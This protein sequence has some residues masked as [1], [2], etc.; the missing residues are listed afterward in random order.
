MFDLDSTGVVYLIGVGFALLIFAGALYYKYDQSTKLANH[1]ILANIKLQKL[2]Q[3]SA[4]RKRLAKAKELFQEGWKVL[5]GKKKSGQEKERVKC[6]EYFA[7]AVELD[8]F[9]CG[10]TNKFEEK[11]EEVGMFTFGNVTIIGWIA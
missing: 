2:P 11:L 4:T 10:W 3:D 5:K 1:Y 7:K 9:A 8:E 6:L